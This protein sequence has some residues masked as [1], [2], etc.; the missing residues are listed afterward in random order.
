MG[1][2]RKLFVVLGLIA[3]AGSIFL[4]RY[5]SGLNTESPAK[6]TPKVQVNVP[7]IEAS[8]TTIASNID[9]TG[10][11]IS[12][13]KI[14]L[15]SEV[16]GVLQA[17]HKPFKAGIFFNRGDTLI[18][19][20]MQEEM[21]NLTAQKFQF[22]ALLSTILP[23]ISLDF[24]EAYKK[25]NDYL[26][27]FNVHSKLSD[28]PEVTSDQLRLFLISNDV[29]A[30]FHQIKR[31]EIRMEK[32]TILAP[33]DGTVTESLVNPG[34]LVQTGQRL[35]SFQ[36]ANML[37]IEASIDVDFIPLLSIGD[38]VDMQIDTDN[39]DFFPA[40]VIRINQQ[41]DNQTQTVLTYLK[42]E[43][44]SKHIRPGQ[45]VDGFIKGRT[46]TE[47]VSLPLKSVVMNQNVFIVDDSVATLK[48]VTI[49]TQQ[50]D[51]VMV[52]GLQKGDLVIDEFYSPAFEGTPVAPISQ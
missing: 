27:S 1:K 38:R 22:A 51:S 35:G 23:D 29:Y 44:I 48:P 34:A 10:R 8:P 20:E 5:L 36:R 26:L 2:Y 14:D 18:H 12:A 31:E 39:R 40:R 4:A 19:L 15:F 43:S 28:L 45:F 21:E 52:R 16:V 9:F 24:P 46:F 37:E 42:P 13:Q 11:V 7:V 41:V 47:A 50:Q 49:L 32:F 33:F 17:T 30:Q 3:L 25:W 6:T